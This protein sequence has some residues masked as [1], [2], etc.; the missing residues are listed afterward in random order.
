MSRLSIVV[1]L[2]ALI[3]AAPAAA[4]PIIYD[5]GG[6]NQFDGFFAD[7]SLGVSI[8]AE[9]FV[10]QPGM[11]TITDAHWWGACPDINGCV[12]PDFTLR[13]YSDDNGT[14]GTLIDTRSVGAANQGKTGN[15]LVDFPEYAY[16]ATFAPLI[17][18][19]NTPYWFGLSENTGNAGV[20][21]GG[22]GWETTGDPF[23]GSHME[24][25]NATQ[26][27][28]SNVEDLA[29]NL[30]GTTTPVPEPVT[31]TLVGLGVLGFAARRRI[32]RSRAE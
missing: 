12:A 15:L 13:F 19:A 31:M 23:G 3:S 18:S 10:L 4:D 6:P 27:W 26:T 30:T 20:S 24:W 11:T 22:W 1:T 8:L 29:F 25:F 32:G 17:L 9:S 7:G 21:G 28:G 5:G 2:V 14:V 16:S